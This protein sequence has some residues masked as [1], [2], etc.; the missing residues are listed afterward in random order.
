VK[1]SRIDTGGAKRFKIYHWALKPTAN[2]Y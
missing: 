2:N 1:F